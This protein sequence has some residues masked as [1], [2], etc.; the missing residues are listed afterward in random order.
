MTAGARG[1]TW[2]QLTERVSTLPADRARKI[3]DRARPAPAA[4]DPQR[5]PVPPTSGLPTPVPDPVYAS[6]DDYLAR[7]T[8]QDRRRWCAVKVRTANRARLMSGCPAERITVDDVWAV[9]AK[10][11]GRCAYCGSLALE[12]RPTGN[13][14][15]PLPWEHVGRRIGSLSH[16][17]S[18]FEGGANT[19]ENLVWSCLWCNTWPSERTPGASD[20]G[21][22]HPYQ[23]DAQD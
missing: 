7:T 20:R 4:P 6:W 11:R 14:G 15:A 16:R 21:G 2:A 19:G 17:R 8:R 3:L 23:S 5:A 13:G 22:L 9:L 1:P 18:R 12:P 10:A